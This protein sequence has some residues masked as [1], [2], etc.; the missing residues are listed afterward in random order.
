NDSIDPISLSY[1]WI[2]PH[3]DGGFRMWYGSTLAW[4]AG[5]GEM[6][7]VI[8]HAYSK[9]GNKWLRTGVNV[10]Y[11][12]G[13]FQAFSRPTVIR[14]PEGEFEMWFSFR[15]NAGT[16]YRIGYARSPDGE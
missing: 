3:Q 12:L 4:D 10:P 13:R 11:E 14:N 1:P 8:R 2:L 9:D 16:K 15:G 5:N 7:H 6:L